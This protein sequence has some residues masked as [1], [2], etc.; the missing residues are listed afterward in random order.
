M[1][2]RSLGSALIFML[3]ILLLS[4]WGIYS[5]REGVEKAVIEHMESGACVI[6]TADGGY[7]V[8]GAAQGLG[9]WRRN[10]LLIRTDGFGREMWR[11]FFGRGD[12]SRGNAVVETPDGGYLV[13]GT[14]WVSKERKSDVY[15]VRTGPGGDML[16]DMT[17]GGEGRDEGLSVCLSEDGG[18]VIAGRTGSFGAGK[19]DLYL[20]R[21]D[22]GGNEL[23]SRTFGGKGR[24]E[25]R[26]VCR[27]PDGGYAAAG[28]TGSFGAGE[29]DAYLVIADSGGNL[30]HAG[31]YGGVHSE[32]GNSVCQARDGGFVI[33]GNTRRPGTGPGDVYVV[34]VDAGGKEVW[35]KTFG[36][37]HG[38]YGNSV[39]RTGGDEYM[40]AGNTWPFGSMGESK[41]YLVKVGKEGDM[42]WGRTIAGAGSEYGLS[43]CSGGES[44]YVIAG[45]T[46]SAIGKD[47]DVYL[48]KTGEEGSV[49]WSRALGET[50]KD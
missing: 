25:G 15:L 16:W 12:V 36:G 1:D 37:R 4:F 20:I 30:L 9:G 41:I 6:E 3:M 18:C 38:D 39:I 21:T 8:A 13:A 11:R 45:R 7:A 10:V 24:D 44:G 27:R 19:D 35:S 17:Y 14:A 46:E 31:T 48:V 47:E 2:K 50:V 49:E 43:I 34:K 26:S 29:A 32:M 40:V 28:M 42:L 5:R 33:A 23:W 22:A